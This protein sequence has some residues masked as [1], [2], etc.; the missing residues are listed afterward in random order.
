M[1]DHLVIVVVLIIVCSATVVFFAPEVPV[2][3]MGPMH[4]EFIE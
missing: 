1:K 3:L 2:L 4:V